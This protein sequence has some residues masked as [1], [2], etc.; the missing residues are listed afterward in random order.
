MP[1]R[2]KEKTFEREEDSDKNSDEVSDA[3]EFQT[4]RENQS[5]KK[6]KKSG[7]E[8]VE[9]VEILDEP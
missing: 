3:D 2:Q 1:N 8:V 9:I 5:V 4:P 6:R 7:E